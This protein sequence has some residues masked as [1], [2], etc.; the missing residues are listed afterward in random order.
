MNDGTAIHLYFQPKTGIYEAYGFSAFN[1]YRVAEQKSLQT[2]A[3][4]SV[5]VAMPVVQITK[6]QIQKLTSQ[7]T[8][9]I[10]L[11]I[12]VPLNRDEYRIWTQKLK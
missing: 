5:Q 1:L 2:I 12:D 4:Y 10:S 7:Q 11:K 6:E 9:T 8:E 3:S